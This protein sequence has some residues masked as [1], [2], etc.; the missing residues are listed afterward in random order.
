MWA[1][2]ATGDTVTVDRTTTSGYDHNED[3]NGRH[4]N[5]GHDDDGN[6][7]HDDGRQDDTP[8]TAT[9]GMTTLRD[10]GDCSSGGN[11]APAIP[12][13]IA[14]SD[15]AAAFARE[16]ATDAQDFNNAHASIVAK[17]RP[18]DVPPKCFWHQ[19]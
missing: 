14:T 7:R 6:R 18:Q 3:G 13:S 5:N 17:H 8:T 16:A 9:D 11:I 1:T 4:S 12:N 19:T 10:L 15:E 2:T